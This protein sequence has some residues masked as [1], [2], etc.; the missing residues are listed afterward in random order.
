[1]RIFALK[2]G[3]H[4]DR[5]MVD[6]GA[7]LV[8]LIGQTSTRSEKPSQTASGELLEHHGEK[9]VPYTAQDSVMG[10]TYQVTD[11]EGPVAAVSSMNDGGMTAVSSPPGAWCCDEAPLIE[12]SGWICQNVQRMVA[13]RREQHVD[14]VEQIAGDPVIEEKRQDAPSSDFD[15]QDNEE[16]QAKNSTWTHD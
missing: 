10:I 14:Q 8:Q 3:L 16:A 9:L 15:T 13:L 4:V 5:V 12:R 6:S 11:V 1:M 7:A 2:A